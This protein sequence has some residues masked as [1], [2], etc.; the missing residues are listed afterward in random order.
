[1]YLKICV[2][3]NLPSNHPEK[4]KF[5]SEGIVMCDTIAFGDSEQRRWGE[6]EVIDRSEY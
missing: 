1:M 2:T 4:G 3:D 6:H 5:R